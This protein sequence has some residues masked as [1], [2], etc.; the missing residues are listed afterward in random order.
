MTLSNGIEG[1]TATNTPYYVFAYL[2]ALRDSGVTNMFGSSRYVVAD[3]NISK[4][5]AD[6]LVGAWMRTFDGES[7]I[8]DRLR[9]VQ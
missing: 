2:D 9:N 3:F 5:V 6:A 4:E 1:I 7:S 8:E